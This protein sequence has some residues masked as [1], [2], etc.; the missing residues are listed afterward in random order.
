[1]EIH[2]EIQE[3]LKYK[4]P[5]RFTGL[6]LLTI[7]WPKPFEEERRDFWVLFFGLE[8][9]SNL[10]QAWFLGIEFGSDVVCFHFCFKMW[11]HERR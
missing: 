5:V 7:G 4:D 8:R 2:P 1:M 6:D 3:W 9:P 11:R 10:E